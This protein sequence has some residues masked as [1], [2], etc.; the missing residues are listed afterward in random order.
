MKK[1][2]SCRWN[3]WFDCG[4]PYPTDHRFRKEINQWLKDSSEMDQDCIPIA[5]KTD[6]PAWLKKEK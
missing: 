5:P 4:L 1:C 3:S 6:C 2:N